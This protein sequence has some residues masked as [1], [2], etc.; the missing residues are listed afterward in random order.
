MQQVN[1][2]HVPVMLQPVIDI[3]N[4]HSGMRVVDA[5]LGGG[6]YTRVLLNQVGPEGKVMAFDWDET[7]MVRFRESIVDDPILSS[8]LATGRLILVRGSYAT[9]PAA[10]QKND[11]EGVDAIVADLGLSSDQ[12]ADPKRGISFQTNGPLDMRLNSDEIVQAKHI[13]DQWDGDALA[14]L[15]RTYGDEPE[16]K[17]IATAIVEARRLAAI[18]TTAELRQIIWENVVPARRRGKIHPATKVFQALRIA[19]NSERAHLEQ[20]LKTIPSALVPGG[21]AAI[22]SFHSGEDRIVKHLFQEA[23]RSENAQLVWVNK[24]PLVPSEG[25]V[26]S[27]PRAR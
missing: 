3:L 4:L 6:G 23:I 11:W 15:F 7:V 2:E 8:S 25:E 5:T 24:K 26:Q 18:V 14:D 12:L 19:V 10:L 1:T 16:A 17:R 9:L 20:F 22:V 27:N 13:L 21:R